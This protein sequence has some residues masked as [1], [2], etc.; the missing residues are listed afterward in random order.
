MAFLAGD[1]EI[2]Q[3]LGMAAAQR[4]TAN[5]DVSKMVKAYEELYEELVDRSHRPNESLLQGV[6]H[7]G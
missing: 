6:R 2:R 4:A 7:A 3:S 1:R 5:F